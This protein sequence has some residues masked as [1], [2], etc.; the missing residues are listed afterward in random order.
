[1]V[2]PESVQKR[3]VELNS[4]SVADVGDLYATYDTIFDLNTEEKQLERKFVLEVYRMM[5]YCKIPIS[6]Q[7]V[8]DAMA[9]SNVGTQLQTINS[10]NILELTEDFLYQTSFGSLEFAHISVAEY[11]RQ[12]SED[13][14]VST[15]VG[16]IALM[17]V[18]CLS[19]CPT[20]DF[21]QH[22]P[23]PN[24]FFA[25]AFIYWERHCSSLSIEDRQSIGLSTAI[26]VWMTEGSNFS[27][28]SQYWAEGSP[29][30]D[31]RIVY[32]SIWSWSE[33][34]ELILQSQPEDSSMRSSIWDS[35]GWPGFADVF[36]FNMMMRSGGPDILFSP[37]L[38]DQHTPFL[39]AVG[40][41][42]V[43][44][45]ELLLKYDHTPNVEGYIDKKALS[46]AI[47]NGH[48]SVVEALLKDER[49]DFNSPIEFDSSIEFGRTPLS[50][51]AEEGNLK[52]VQLLLA[53]GAVVE[54][55]RGF[56]RLFNQPIYMAQKNGHLEV[57]ETLKEAAR[58][59]RMSKL[60][61]TVRQELY[62]DELD[63]ED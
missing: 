56:S 45:V 41:G 50:F 23:R 62:G 10:A 6:L 21:S 2:L 8:T 43:D 38:S 3:L 29:L 52:I 49:V 42:D 18:N 5:L 11:L 57:V 4:G 28:W 63:G 26:F 13:F 59:Q 48:E 40:G 58:A 61:R 60:T 27:I 35:D 34:L 31:C 44:V 46:I 12:R 20:N 16:K 54:K 1:M 47:E 7:A 51:A 55:S 14:S 15:C 19:S 32:C 33:V 30:Q 39:Y 25:Y 24:K 17:C 37:Y 36:T 9:F 53:A 22:R